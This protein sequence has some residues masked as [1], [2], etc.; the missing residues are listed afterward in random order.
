MVPTPR[1]LVTVSTN[2]VAR[3]NGCVLCGK[4]GVLLRRR[5]P[6]ELAGSYASY[7]GTGLP[8]EIVQKYFREPASEYLCRKC[9][10][11]IY[12]PDQLGE[13]DFYGVLSRQYDWYYQMGWDKEIAIDYLQCINA[14]SVVEI[15]CG[16][17]RFLQKLRDCSIPAFGIDIN[18]SALALAR[19]RGLDVRLP[20][21]GKMEHCDVLVLFQTIEHLADPVQ[22]LRQCMDKYRPRLTMLSAPCYETILGHTTDPLS[23]PPHHRTAWSEKGFSALAR[24]FQRSV[25]KVWYQPLSFDGLQWK[26]EREPGG[27]IPGIPRLPNNRMG[28]LAFR[29]LQL[30]GVSWATREHSIMVAIA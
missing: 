14:R 7:F 17:G 2:H 3:G 13:G 19:E 27:R 10:V 21:E 25:K 6:A 22:F 9:G 8:S 20:G 4:P 1:A 23:W 18:E 12:T 30:L 15:G 24:F 5:D 16:D 28:R 11:R 26:Q 29:L